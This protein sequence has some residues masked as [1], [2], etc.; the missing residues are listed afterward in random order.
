MSIPLH[1]D[2]MMDQGSPPRPLLGRFRVVVVDENRVLGECVTALR[3]E[4]YE[5]VTCDAAQGREALAVLDTPS[6]D[7]VT[8]NVVHSAPHSLALLR[9]GLQMCGRGKAPSERRAVGFLV[10]QGSGRTSRVQ[11]LLGSDAT[12]APQL[13]AS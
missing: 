9:A 11:Q 6:S 10:A 3:A 5:V 7:V 4:G 1:A 2:L 8:V 12:P 13:R